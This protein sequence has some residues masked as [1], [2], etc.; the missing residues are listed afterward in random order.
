MFVFVFIGANLPIKLTFRHPCPPS[1]FTRCLL[2]IGHVIPSQL[3]RVED[4]L[5]CNG[6]D[7]TY[8]VE[9][10]LISCVILL[11]SV[12][13]LQCRVLKGFVLGCS[14]FLK[15]PKN[16]KVFH[17]SNFHLAIQPFLV[18]LYP[19]LKH[20]SHQENANVY[21]HK[22][23]FVSNKAISPKV[24][25]PFARSDYTLA[26]EWVNWS[27]PYKSC[28]LLVVFHYFVCILKF[29]PFLFPHP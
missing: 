4:Q 17:C 3:F 18:L 29:T 27:V 8:T 5:F 15:Q 1:L 24:I 7:T 12:E 19:V 25:A 11:R 13:A 23:N 2:P 28:G 14:L 22:F 9:H 6:C 20:F 16:K 26:Y 10:I 21:S